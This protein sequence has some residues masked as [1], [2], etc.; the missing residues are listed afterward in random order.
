MEVAKAGWLVGTMVG[1]AGVMMVCCVVTG[2]SEMTGTVDVDG[3]MG[4]ERAT[5]SD[6]SRIS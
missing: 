2:A 3:L 6:E 5:G 1:V 4:G